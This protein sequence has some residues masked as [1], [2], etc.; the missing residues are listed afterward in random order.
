MTQT[1]LT[2]AQWGLLN[3]CGASRLIEA[4]RSGELPDCVEVNARIALRCLWENPHCYTWGRWFAANHINNRY[5]TGPVSVRKVIFPDESVR[6][7]VVAPNGRWCDTYEEED[8][9]KHL[10]SLR[11]NGQLVYLTP[12]AV[13]VVERDH[14]WALSR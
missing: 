13:E 4:R 1:E 3:T 2:E 12:S 11:K 9:K 8:A 5:R 10:R 7:T 14:N 6:Y